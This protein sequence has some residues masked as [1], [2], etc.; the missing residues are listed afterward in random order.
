MHFFFNHF[1]TEHAH[2]F[3]MLREKNSQV[4]ITSSHGRDINVGPLTADKS[5]TEPE[6]SDETNEADIEAYVSWI[7]DQALMEKVDVVWPY[8]HRILLAKHVARFEEAGLKLLVSAPWETLEFIE[9]KPFFLDEMGKIGVNVS[10]SVVFKDLNG[11]E[12]GLRFFKD[13]DVC[14][15][16]ASGIGGIGYRRLL[17]SCSVEDMIGSDTMVLGL[18]MLKDML[19]KSDFAQPMMLMP[20]LKSPER[21][22]D[23]ACWN[24]QTL[25]VVT[26]T[27]Q[28]KGQLVGDDE[29]ARNMAIKLVE[30]LGLSG[31]INMQTRIDH[32]G[33]QTLLEINTRASGGTGWT[34]VSGVNLPGLVMD[35]LSG[36]T[37]QTCVVPVK[38]TLAIRRYR[39]HA[40][41]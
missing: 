22:V 37:N 28:N 9:N 41:D 38:N 32:N 10:P 13:Q 31:L 40:L 35:A 5:L 33:E 20:Y 21:S 36:K 6:I 15:K 23:V 24:G 12:E 17:K 19:R 27:R 11:F 39:F 2:I 4:R 29:V 14:I 16:P 7:V 18:E 30:H 1:L 34:R 25:G 8:K 26:R 3:E